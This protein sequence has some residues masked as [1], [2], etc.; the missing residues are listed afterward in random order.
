MLYF[1]WICAILSSPIM[2][3]VPLL[4]MPQINSELIDVF[5]LHNENK[6]HCLTYDEKIPMYVITPVE[7]ES[8]KLTL[9]NE[10]DW[11]QDGWVMTDA[12]NS[13]QAPVTDKRWEC[14]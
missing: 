8:K 9:I 2:C 4:L 13:F 11:N 14:K 3:T 7:E 12:N 5:T 10:K 1:K 6:I